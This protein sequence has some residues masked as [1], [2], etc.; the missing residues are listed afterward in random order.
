M[1]TA[2]ALLAAGLS[3]LTTSFT[4]AQAPARPAGRIKVVTGTAFVDR[5]GAATVAAVGQ[6]VFETDVLRTGADGQL[7]LTLRDDSRVS[8]SPSSAVR[9]EQLRFAPG[10]SQV[11]LTL[12]FL[13]G[14]AAYISGRIAKLSPDAVRL[15][16]PNAIVGVRGTTVVIQVDES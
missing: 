1:R 15:E 12:R 16:T 7:G 8:L 4:L 10:E 3:L 13:K 9:V 6:E 14:T 5:Q 11:A 2:L